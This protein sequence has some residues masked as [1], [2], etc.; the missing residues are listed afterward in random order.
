MFLLLAQMNFLTLPRGL[1][2]AFPWPYDS[3]PVAL[4]QPSRGPMTAFPW[5]RV[6]V[7]QPEVTSTP[8]SSNGRH[9]RAPW[10]SGR[11]TSCRHFRLYVQQPRKLTM[12][13]VPIGFSPTAG[14]ED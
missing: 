1:M 5:R 4:W 8:D 10:G 9:Q 11:Q 14:L 12:T 6:A 3:L 13:A 2:A 7:S